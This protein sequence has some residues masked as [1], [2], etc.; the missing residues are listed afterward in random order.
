ML[1][2]SKAYSINYLIIIQFKKVMTKR[3]GSVGRK[4]PDCLFF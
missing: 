2:A 3:T 4:N 1:D